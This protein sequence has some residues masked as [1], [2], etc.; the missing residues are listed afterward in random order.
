MNE[1]QRQLEILIR[2]HPEWGY[3]KLNRQLKSDTGQGIR[4]Q[5]LLDV[6]RKVLRHKA[7]T[8][9]AETR[10]RSIKLVYQII[11]A[12]VK[13]DLRNSGFKD[14]EIKEI[15]AEERILKDG[16]II[17]TTPPPIDGDTLRDMAIFRQDILNGL[18]ESQYNDAI[19]KN[20]KD[21][22]WIKEDSSFDI[23]GMF[24]KFFD[25]QSAGYRFAHDKKGSGHIQFNKGNVKEQKRR[26]RERRKG[27]KDTQVPVSD[28]GT[29]VYTTDG[30]IAY[31][32]KAPA[33]PSK[34]ASW[35][36]QK[37]VNN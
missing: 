36:G 27:E 28:R 34:S 20:Y 10:T 32:Q 11:P 30:K 6:K 7:P 19:E 2:Q 18:D 35:N 22:G 37:W 15:M 25:G 23:W 29:P 8:P 12:D 21:N 5:V 31:W 24:R 1:K 13:S 9:V 16:T 17:S 4:K 26:A 3:V 14:F 33:K